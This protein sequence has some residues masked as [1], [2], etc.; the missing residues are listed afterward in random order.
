MSAAFVGTRAIASS[1]EL[2]QFLQNMSASSRYYFLRW[3]HKVSGFVRHPDD[4]SSPE[5]QMLTPEF[6]VRWQQTRQGYDLLLLHTR[7]PNAAW[8]FQPVGQNWVISGSLTTHLHPKGK[9]Q[10]EAEKRQDTRFPKAFIYPDGLRLQQQYFQN[11]ETG[12]VHFIAL[13]LLP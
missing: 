13:I 7:E 5:G 4:F 2:E 1:T 12:T 6:E 10:E 3:A 9:P 11:S 8:G